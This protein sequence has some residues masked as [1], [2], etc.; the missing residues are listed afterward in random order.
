M[1]RQNAKTIAFREINLLVHW[2]IFPQST[3]TL[4]QVY[5]NNLHL[6]TFNTLSLKI[7]QFSLLF[8]HKISN[9]PITTFSFRET[10][11]LHELLQNKCCFAN[12]YLSYAKPVLVCK[13]KILVNLSKQ[14]AKK[15]ISTLLIIKVPTIQKYSLNVVSATRNP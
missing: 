14:I 13:R 4:F 5:Y 2:N 11:I 7:F 3:N 8:I 6:N 12:Y 10:W 1:R 9:K 15:C